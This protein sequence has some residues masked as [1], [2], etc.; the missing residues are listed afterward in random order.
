MNYRTDLIVNLLF[1]A[2]SDR[3]LPVRPDAN[4]MM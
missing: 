1:A 2:G 4:N 3:R